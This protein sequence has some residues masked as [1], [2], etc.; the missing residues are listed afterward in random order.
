MTLGAL[1]GIPEEA[2]ASDFVGTA[3]AKVVRPALLGG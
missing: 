1:L 3:N 2:L